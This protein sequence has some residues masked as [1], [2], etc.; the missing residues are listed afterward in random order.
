[1]RGFGFFNTTFTRDIRQL[2]DLT[3]NLFCQANLFTV[4][5]FTV[6]VIQTQN[7]SNCSIQFQIIAAAARKMKKKICAAIGILSGQRGMKVKRVQNADPV[8]PW[9][10]TVVNC[11]PPKGEKQII[12]ITMNILYMKLYKLAKIQ[13]QYSIVSWPLKVR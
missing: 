2:S 3:T 5:R 13:A 1:M 10:P 6:Q 11:F 12:P 4:C 7:V 8:N 9:S